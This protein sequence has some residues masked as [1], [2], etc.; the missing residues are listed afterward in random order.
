MKTVKIMFIGF[1]GL[2]IAYIIFN[3]ILGW[4]HKRNEEKRLIKWMNISVVE[5]DDS[6]PP[7]LVIEA[8]NTGPRIIGQTHFRLLF[9]IGNETIW[10]ADQDFANF[11]PAEKRRLTLKSR[12]S[13]SLAAGQVLKGQKVHY[14]LGV[15]PEW[16]RMKIPL[17][18][19][20]VL[21]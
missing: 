13:T 4:F 17:E 3:S 10:R 8:E 5:I 7:A 1:V 14:W 18:G 16:G 15:F 21:R 11:Q 20:F 6:I 19:D 12:L 9:D 2:A